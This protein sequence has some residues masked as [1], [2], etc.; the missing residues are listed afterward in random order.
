[1]R[2]CGAWHARL[3]F[4]NPD[5][6]R[7][8]AH[9]H[10]VGG[11]GCGEANPDRGPHFLCEGDDAMPEQFVPVNRKASPYDE[12]G[13]D[14]VN[15]PLPRKFKRGLR[16]ITDAAD[17]VD[18]QEEAEAEEEKHGVRRVLRGRRRQRRRHRRLRN[19]G[20]GNETA[21]A[22]RMLLSYREEE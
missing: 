2:V 19:G 20:G 12:K 16:A 13:W 15:L 10:L 4:V 11:P 5:V 7:L 1:M 22:R 17:A 18:G 8:P 6:A 9:A 3:V 21:G 14:L